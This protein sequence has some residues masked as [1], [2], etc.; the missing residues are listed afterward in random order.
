MLFCSL[1]QLVIP[2]PADQ[3]SPALKSQLMC[4]VTAMPFIAV[5]Q[6]G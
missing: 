4:A 3:V 2:V 6:P 1:L 5:W